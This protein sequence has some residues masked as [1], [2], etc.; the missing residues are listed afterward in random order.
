MSRFSRVPLLCLVLLGLLPISPAS[1]SPSVP[2]HLLYAHAFSAVMT[3]GGRYAAFEPTEGTTRVIDSTT[4]AAV[5]RADPVGC[6]GGLAG[7]GAGEFLYSCIPPG[8][9]PP[10]LGPL[11]AGVPT[12]ACATPPTGP[13]ARVL[14]VVEDIDGGTLHVVAGSD[15][16]S[17]GAGGEYPAFD[18][19][20]SQWL[21]SP[22]AGLHV[23]VTLY[24]DWH[25]AQQLTDDKEAKSS[26]RSTEDLDVP[27]LLRPLCAPLR[28]TAQ[29]S[30]DGV[31]NSAFLPFSYSP[32][33]GASI[34][35]AGGRLLLSR[36]GSTRTAQLRGAGVTQFQLSGGWIAWATF[37]RQFPAEPSLDEPGAIYAAALHSIGRR[38]LATTFLYTGAPAG[39]VS[40]TPEALYDSTTS[41]G[42]R[43]WDV[44]T[45][46]LRR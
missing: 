28:R 16:I 7:V 13:Y 36:C 23:E 27:K 25:T 39:V 43:Y 45:A 34:A 4:G 3:D 21:S 15:R 29:A 40:D 12:I 46:G 1:A 14:Y 42:G 26:V 32:P 20:G 33:F 44:Y 2:L 19:I 9:Q 24:L 11:T 22:F 8:C 30:G 6:A 18:A 35:G 5:D 37:S 38:W 41:A 17:P 10:I 31:T